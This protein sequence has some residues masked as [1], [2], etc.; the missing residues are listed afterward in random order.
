MKY[1]LFDSVPVTADPDKAYWVAEID[2]HPDRDRIWGT[3]AA[4][5]D[6]HNQ[7]MEEEWWRGYEDGA[8]QEVI[9]DNT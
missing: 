2:A 5:R 9:N 6:Q 7:R 8:H 3:L 1:S 4:L